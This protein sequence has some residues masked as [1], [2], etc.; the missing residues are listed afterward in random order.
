MGNNPTGKN[1]REAAPIGTIKENKDGYL[2]AKVGDETK[3]Q[4]KLVHRMVM[5]QHLGRPLERYETV[6]HKNGDRKD[7]RIDNLEILWVGDHPAGQRIKDLIPTEVLEM[8]A[9]IPVC[10]YGNI[11]PTITCGSYEDGLKTILDITKS[12]SN[13]PEARRFGDIVQNSMSTHLDDQISLREQNRGQLEVLGDGVLFNKADHTYSKNGLPYL[14]GSTFAHM[15]EQEFPREAV[16][17]KVAAKEDK[18]VEDVLEGWDAKGQISLDYGTLIHKCI[19]TW[20]Q[21]GELPNNEYLQAIV[22]DWDEVFG[23][24]PIDFNELFVQDDDHQL[25]GVADAIGG[26]V[27]Y[28]WKTGDIHQKIK[29]TLG[30]EFPN[31]RLSLYTLQLNFYKYII[32]QNGGKVKKLVIGWLNGEH[33]EKVDVPIIDIKPYLEQVWTAKKI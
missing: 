4:W 6:H 20:C 2:I 16:A 22:K 21:H 13:S 10:Q 33:W 7:N 24:D 32:E 17:S 29:H 18:A 31:D 12:L 25:C 5:E 15:F 9:T 1:G 28:D 19:E 11:Q 27:L 3:S 8:K 30:K 14:S 23:N 26:D